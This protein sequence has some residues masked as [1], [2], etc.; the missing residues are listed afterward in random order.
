MLQSSVDTANSSE[1][2][3]KLWAHEMQRIFGDRLVDDVDRLWFVNNCSQI[4]KRYGEGI[5]A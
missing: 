3:L 2:M 4:S 5:D 1:K